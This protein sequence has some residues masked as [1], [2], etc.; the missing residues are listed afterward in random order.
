M[1]FVQAKKNQEMQSQPAEPQQEPPYPEPNRAEVYQKM[2]QFRNLLPRME[3][4]I[5]MHGRMGTNPELIRKYAG[6][7]PSAPA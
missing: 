3:K 4:L 5:E 7:V 6:Y 1:K 2:E